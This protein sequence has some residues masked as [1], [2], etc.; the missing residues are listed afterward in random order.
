MVTNPLVK[1]YKNCSYVC[2][3]TPVRGFG[4]F[5]NLSYPTT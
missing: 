1:Q 3:A 5:I 4:S 2:L